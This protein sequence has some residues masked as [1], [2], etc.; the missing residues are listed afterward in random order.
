MPQPPSIPLGIWWG[1]AVAATFAFL[2]FFVPIMPNRRYRVQLS[3]APFVAVL[4]VAISAVVKHHNIEVSLPLYTAVVAGIPLGFLGHRK[5]LR[6]KAL[7]IA[8]NGSN[9]NNALSMAAQVQAFVVI[10]I[11]GGIGAWFSMVA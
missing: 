5:E 11:V 7:D 9:R 4:L 3:L 6:E 10:L 8:E 2:A 1:I